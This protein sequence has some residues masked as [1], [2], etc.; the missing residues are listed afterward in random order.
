MPSLWTRA[1]LS[2]RHLVGR[3]VLQ[4]WEDDVPGRCAELAFFFLFSIFPLLFFLTTLLGYVTAASPEFRGDLF[5]YI[6]RVSP[7]REVTELIHDTLAQVA[8]ARTG[9][10]LGVSLAVTLWVASSAMVAVGRT[11]NAAYGLEETRSIVWSRVNA[12]LLTLTFTVLIVAALFLIFYGGS[13]GEALASRLGLDFVFGLAW[14]PVRWLLILT[15][16]VFSFELVYNY[17]PNLGGTHRRHWI[18]PGALTGVVLW[19]AASFGLRTYLDY[20][21]F[22]ATAYGSLGAVIL[23]LVWFYLTAFA[24]LMG[25]E[26]NSEIEREAGRGH[27][28]PVRTRRRRRKARV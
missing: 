5:E 22:Y 16:V 8:A 9:T 2:W 15:F 10:K 26:V 25:G 1:G 12:V 18:T 23:L 3:I 14:P 7:S 19:L 20:F 6:A 21:S 11:L 4:I 28:Q 13:R 24:V 17:A 27:E